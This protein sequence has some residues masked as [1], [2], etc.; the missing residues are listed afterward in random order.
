MGYQSDY[1][2]VLEEIETIKKMLS[3]LPE[4]DLAI[5][6]DG[7]YKK[8]VA[9]STTGNTAIPKKDRKYAER[10]ALKHY[11]TVKLS[12]LE[13]KKGAYEVLL[14]E[15]QPEDALLA[16]DSP[17]NELLLPQITK[18]TPDDLRM[19]QNEQYEHNTQYA[20]GLSH[21]TL[22][23]V[24][25]RSKSEAMIAN[26]LYAHGIP[27]RYE[28]ALHFEGKVYFPDFTIMRPRDRKLLYWEH[29]GLIDDRRYR[30]KM[31]SKIRDYSDHGILPEVD[32]IMTFETRTA[33]LDIVKIRHVIE[34][35]LV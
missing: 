18:D 9:R 34:E 26:E 22:R 4:E 27:F 8:W 13:E 11:L 21:N 32:L 12:G 14:R 3:Q 28:C 7:K 2:H 30:E 24:K 15:S 29:F 20:E 6:K 35:Y 16:P 1:L 19:W 33:P 31:L 23:N 10:L 17:F 25:V 5:W